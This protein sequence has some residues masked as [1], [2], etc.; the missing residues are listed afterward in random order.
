MHKLA[1]M[2]HIAATKNYFSAVTSFNGNA[3]YTV[4]SIMN[5]PNL[6]PE[7]TKSTEFGLEMSFLKNRIGFDINKYTRFNGKSNY[8]C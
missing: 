4:P 8:P 2:R 6:Q 5:N 3:I 1:L 7:K